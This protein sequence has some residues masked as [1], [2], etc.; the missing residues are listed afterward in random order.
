MKLKGRII[1][2]F[3]L[4]SSVDVQRD[5]VNQKFKMKQITTLQLKRIQLLIVKLC[6]LSPQWLD[7]QIRY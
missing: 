5:F 6:F 2:C 1:H 7:P 3:L 4:M